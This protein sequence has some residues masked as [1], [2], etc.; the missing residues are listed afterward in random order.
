MGAEDV[1][2]LIKAISTWRNATGS[3]LFRALTQTDVRGPT[4][5]AATKGGALPG[6]ASAV[7]V[8]SPEQLEAVGLTPPEAEL[9]Q[10]GITASV[11]AAEDDVIAMGSAIPWSV[12]DAMIRYKHGF[13]WIAPEAV[14]VRT[15]SESA[16][17]LEQ[18][19][20]TRILIPVTTESGVLF[21]ADEIGMTQAREA[22][23]LATDLLDFIATMFVTEM[24]S[25]A[26]EWGVGLYGD[27][28]LDAAQLKLERRVIEE[29][30]KR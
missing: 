12:R 10:A 20:P 3:D 15:D 24:E 23:E 27:A 26:G 7:R 21:D 17:L 13:S 4:Y 14:L 6:I 30:R 11:L 25:A 18:R 16:A 28:R 1:E 2:I 19:E 22:L 8:P 9:L 29:L 5:L